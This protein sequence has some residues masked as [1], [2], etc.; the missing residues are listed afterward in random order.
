MLTGYVAFIWS[1]E[2]WKRNL[3]EIISYITFYLFFHFRITSSKIGLN[4]IL[5]LIKLNF[6]K[7][8]KGHSDKPLQKTKVEIKE[9][10][11]T[12][13]RV[14]FYYSLPLSSLSSKSILK[15]L[16]NPFHDAISFNTSRKRHNTF[17][18]VMFLGGIEKG[19][20]RIK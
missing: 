16:N 15:Y 4:Y 2:V 12:L 10:E 1:L 13:N 5:E 17:A 11:S 3:E 18:F 9:T 20:S 14:S 6:N 7:S 19:T 8:L